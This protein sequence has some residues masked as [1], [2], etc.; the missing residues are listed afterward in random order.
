MK[1]GL[2]IP[3]QAL[4]VG[5]VPTLPALVPTLPALVP[6]RP[7]YPSP[8]PPSSSPVQY[9]ASSSGPRM[10][11]HAHTHSRPISLN[12]ESQTVCVHCAV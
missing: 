11:V 8:Y 1:I 6:T 2:K 5:P 7:P 12:I 4:A 3:S 9:T 10:R